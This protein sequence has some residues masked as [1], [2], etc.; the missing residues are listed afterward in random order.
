MSS[1]DDDVESISSLVSIDSTISPTDAKGQRKKLIQS[2]KAN[3][4]CRRCNEI[5]NSLERK[6]KIKSQTISNHIR[7]YHEAKLLKKLTSKKSTPTYEL[8]S[9]NK[10]LASIKD[11]NSTGNETVIPEA[12]PSILPGSTY[13]QIEE[14]NM[15]TR[16]DNEFITP[17]KT[18]K[19][20]TAFGDSTT[21]A[22]IPVSNR[23]EPL[24]QE[25]PE[26]TSMEVADNLPENSQSQIRNKAQETISQ[27]S[28][29]PPPIVLPGYLRSHAE[30]INNIN[31]LVKKKYSL[32]YAKKSVVIYC[33]CPTDWMNLKRN[34]ITEKREFHTYAA[35]NERTHAFVLRGLEGNITA[36]DIKESLIDE[37]T[38]TPREVYLMKGTFRPLYLVVLDSSYTLAKLRGKVRSILNVKISWENRKNQREMTQCRKC[39]TWGHVARNCHRTT[40]CS[41]CAGNHEITQCQP[42]NP[43]KCA[44]CGESHR[45]FDSSCPVYEYRLG[46]IRSKKTLPSQPTKYIDAPPPSRPA[47][48]Q[49]RATSSPPAALK[50]YNSNFP[51]T[52]KNRDS[53]NAQA[54]TDETQSKFMTLKSKFEEL[55][56]L[57]NINNLISAI[58]HYTA[59][60]KTCSTAEEKFLISQKFFA[61]ELKHFQI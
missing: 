29:K 24:H 4:K 60:L 7:V 59:Q 25:Q 11:L 43:I 40:K 47:W 58:T 57:I 15:A 45:S 8:L 23:F 34:L 13:K 55:E 61:S 6:Q 10:H 5:L 53:R 42:E 28:D 51:E 30:L 20:D 12:E 14:V 54:V 16:D 3:P 35:S 36:E 37:H 46:A 22:T 9:T 56:S 17:L 38:I 41:K 32:K 50:A 31:I 48:N 26:P 33:E 44:N 19:W 1:S 39:Q 2:L 27:R 49:Q 52:L 21:N 18:V